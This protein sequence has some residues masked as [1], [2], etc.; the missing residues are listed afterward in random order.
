MSLNKNTS[1]LVIAQNGK[2]EGLMS[3]VVNPKLVED[4]DTKDILDNLGSFC[5]N[6]SVNLCY[7]NEGY[8]DKFIDAVNN[9][10]LK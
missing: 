8:K 5:L 7:E 1:D 3:F 9:Q 4:K 6:T 10:K 2:C